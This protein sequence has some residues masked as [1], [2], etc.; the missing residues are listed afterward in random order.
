MATERLCRGISVT[1]DRESPG[2]DNQRVFMELWNSLAVA[3]RMVAA[4]LAKE[5]TKWKFAIFGT[6]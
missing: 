1:V 3:T 4:R 2:A 6:L 5:R